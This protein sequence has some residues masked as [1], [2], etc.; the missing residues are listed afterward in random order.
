MGLGFS[1]ASTTGGCGAVKEGCGGRVGGQE[2]L[3]SEAGHGRFRE[4]GFLEH[5]CAESP[6]RTCVCA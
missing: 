4:Q 6:G 1:W 3:L 5:S 2:A